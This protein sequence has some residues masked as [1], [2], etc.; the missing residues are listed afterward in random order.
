MVKQK[1]T[2]IFVH[3]FW[4]HSS[5]W[6]AW[7]EY[8]R[9]KGYD[10]LALD[11]PGDTETTEGTRQHSERIAG[12]GF[13]EVVEAHAQAIQALEAKPILIGH[14]FGGLI[15][16]KLLGKDL[17]AAAVAIDPAP[18]RGVKATPLSAARNAFVVLRNP[19]NYKR[20]VML[21][22]QQFHYGF[23]NTLTREES[24]EIYQK[25]V[26]PSPG[27][28]MFEAAV[29]NLSPNSPTKV[30]ELAQRGP[31]LITSGGKDHAVPPSITRAIFKRYRKASTVND[32]KEFADRDHALI[33][34][35]GWQEVANSAH[36]W[37]KKQ[38]L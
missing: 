36:D 5:S 23:C 27:R 9:S 21:S 28:V 13:E 12:H 22:P 33:L 24:D 10:T 25:W 6:D 14:S 20:A 38:R 18:M 29:A 3:G 7:Q 19:A 31:L 2:V 37:L 26:I 16:Q 35:A 17:A 30:D 8:F 32:F 34:H 15:V 11:W 1:R 4:L